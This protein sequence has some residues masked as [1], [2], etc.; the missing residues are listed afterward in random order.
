MKLVLGPG[1][2]GG[3]YSMIGSLK[4]IE[5]R[6][7]LFDEISGSSAG[8]MLAL[9]L[10]VGLSVDTIRDKALIMNIRDIVGTFKIKSLLSQFGLMSTNKCR[11]AVV[12]ICGCDPTFRELKKKVHVSAYCVNRSQTVYFNRDTHPDM[13]VADAVCM[14]ISIPLIFASFPYKGDIY[15]D[16]CTEEVLPLSPFLHC[17]PD[18]VFIICIEA[19]ETSNHEITSIIEYISCLFARFS[20]FRPDFPQFTQRL[21]TSIDTYQSINFDMTLEEKLTLY[22]KGFKEKII[23]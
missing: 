10:G 19:T 1:G 8:S 12:H 15:I 13:H 7:D 17:R 14:S 3:L 22:A 16:G 18:D 11:E 20:K 5:E 23:Y 21:S 4:S 9:F 2:L 6:L